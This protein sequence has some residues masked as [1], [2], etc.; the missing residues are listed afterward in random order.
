MIKG[1]STS[2][3]DWDYEPAIKAGLVASFL[4]NTNTSGTVSYSLQ[5]QYQPCSCYLVNPSLDLNDEDH[6]P[7]SFIGVQIDVTSKLR[8]TNPIKIK[9][10]DE[11]TSNM[12]KVLGENGVSRIER[13]IKIEKGWDS[14]KG[15]SFSKASL[16]VLDNFLVKYERFPAGNIPS[17]FLTNS[18]NIQIEWEDLEGNNVEVE[19]FEKHFEYYFGA[20]DEEGKYDISE[21]DQLI[22]EIR[23]IE[24]GN[25]TE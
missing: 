13:F 12:L 7:M 18:G 6:Y 4:Q 22:S 17:V 25:A 14:G 20:T 8:K 11:P 9:S 16:G 10:I 1:L 2:K 19:F 24:R 5:E 21:I 3:A 15:E 23:K